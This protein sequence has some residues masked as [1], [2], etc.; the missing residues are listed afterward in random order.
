MHSPAVFITAVPGLPSLQIFV[1]LDV[2]PAICASTY[3]LFAASRLE[4]GVATFNI[5]LFAMSSDLRMVVVPFTSSAVAG[6][7]VLM[8]TL[9][10]LSLKS[11]PNV[12]PGV[13]DGGEANVHAANAI[14]PTSMNIKTF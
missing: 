2:T 14:D 6:E 11:A 7:D 1:V 13:P 9:P 3:A 12:V 4:V 10:L 5:L 8:P